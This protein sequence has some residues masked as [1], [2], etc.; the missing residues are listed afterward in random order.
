MR[1]MAAHSTGVIVKYIRH[2]VSVIRWKPVSH[3]SLQEPDIFVTG[4][5]DNGVSK[6]SAT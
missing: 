4:S 1:K 5:W 6:L 3:A 2:K